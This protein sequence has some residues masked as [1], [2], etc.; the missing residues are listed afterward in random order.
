MN[1][2]IYNFVSKHFDLAETI[3]VI[4]FAVGLILITNEVKYTLKIMMGVTVAL[5]VL[6]WIMSF[7]PR[8]REDSGLKF[9]SSKISWISLALAVFGILMKL[10]FE[11]KAD[12]LLL[13]SFIC[14]SGSIILNLVTYF[15]EKSQ[16]KVATFVR[17]SI[18]IL[19]CLFLYT[20]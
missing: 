2:T 6:Y 11:E 14:L 12:L 9:F 16:I 4:L 20:L 15:K 19:V 17:S 8:K 10:Q 1:K 18:Y 13:V 7:E 5:A 3:L